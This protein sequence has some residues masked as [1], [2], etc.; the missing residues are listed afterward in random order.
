[1]R[2]GPRLTSAA[3]RALGTHFSKCPLNSSLKPGD[4]KHGI[5]PKRA[6]NPIS[7]EFIVTGGVLGNS[8][9]ACGAHPETPPASSAL[10]ARRPPSSRG[11]GRAD[12]GQGAED[13]CG[14]RGPSSEFTMPGNSSSNAHYRQA[15]RYLVQLFQAVF[16]FDTGLLDVIIDSIEDGALRTNESDSRSTTSRGRRGPQM[17]RGTSTRDK[18]ER[19]PRE[20]RGPA[21]Q[22]HQTFGGRVLCQRQSGP[23][24][25]GRA[26]TN[27]GSSVG[28]GHAGCATLR[29]V[30]K[31]HRAQCEPSA[32]RPSFC[33]HLLLNSWDRSKQSRPA[34]PGRSRRG[35]DTDRHV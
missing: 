12:H 1:M 29:L 31:K 18:P 23:A 10:P 16:S 14:G 17:G 3:D 28:F 33:A 6:K 13:G 7:L 2:R 34:R 32:A 8:E 15:G 19:G 35:L 21:V 9:C 22:W 25:E 30:L 11:H 4:S 24:H 26:P 5:V 20:A 27:Q